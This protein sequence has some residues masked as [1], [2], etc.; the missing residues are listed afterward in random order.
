MASWFLKSWHWLLQTEY[1]IKLHAG[2]VLQFWLSG[3]YRASSS[4]QFLSGLL[5]AGS[6][7]P[8]KL[9]SM[10]QIDLLKNYKY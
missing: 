3:E 7:E 2:V 9:P 4:L 8:V 10:S 6:V 5:H 1:N